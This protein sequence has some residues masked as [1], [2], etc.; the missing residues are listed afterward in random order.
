MLT[1][2]VPSLRKY[3]SPGAQLRYSMPTL[4]GRAHRLAVLRKGMRTPI[5]DPPEGAAAVAG[6]SA[7][8]VAAP[9]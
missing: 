9:T 4:P 1:W 5:S 7:L 6:S 3:F 8:G 2:A